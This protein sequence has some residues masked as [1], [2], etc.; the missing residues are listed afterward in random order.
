MVA[1]KWQE[2][3][4]V[5]VFGEGARALQ[6]ILKS[7]T[8]GF[9]VRTLSALLISHLSERKPITFLMETQQKGEPGMRILLP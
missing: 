1:L 6:H 4:Q 2:L 5:V 8:C 7:N 9:V 3:V